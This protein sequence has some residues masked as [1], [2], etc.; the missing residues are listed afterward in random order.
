MGKLQFANAYL[1]IT[2]RQLLDVD[3]NVIVM[4]NVD[5]NSLALNLNAKI[6]VHNAE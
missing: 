4:P 3:T 6:R 2:D 5:L 1:A